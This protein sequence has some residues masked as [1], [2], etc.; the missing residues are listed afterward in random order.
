ARPPALQ[1]PALTPRLARPAE[2][3]AAGRAWRG[4]GFAEE[5]DAVV[6]Q[7]QRVGGA[8]TTFA[9]GRFERAEFRIPVEVGHPFGF[10]ADEPRGDFAYRKRHGQ[11]I[12]WLYAD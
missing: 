12:A 11:N 10:L 3:F 8:A 6:A 5:V 2:V 9:P 1:R 7:E 4:A